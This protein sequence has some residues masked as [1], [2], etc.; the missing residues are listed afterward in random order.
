M[1]V[2]FGFLL[3]VVD[4]MTNIFKGRTRYISANLVGV[5]TIVGQLWVPS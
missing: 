2:D 1:F 3:W 5:V 4:W